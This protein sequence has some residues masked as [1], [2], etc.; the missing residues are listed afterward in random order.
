MNKHIKRNYESISQEVIQLFV[1]LCSIYEEQKSI[2]SRQKQ[3]V[4]APNSRKRIP[5][6]FANGPNGP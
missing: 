3:P 5:D 2:T 1:S 6:T 4:L